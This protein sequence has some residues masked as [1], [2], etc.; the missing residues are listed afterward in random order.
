MYLNKLLRAG[1]SQIELIYRIMLS[2]TFILFINDIIFSTTSLVNYFNFF[3]YIGC[4]T[5]NKYLYCT[6]YK[7]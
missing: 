6:L 1:L 4:V 3:Y 2:K 7:Y 5:N